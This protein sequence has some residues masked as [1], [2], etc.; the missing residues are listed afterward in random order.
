MLLPYIKPNFEFILLKLA[1]L[2]AVLTENLS[3]DH[4]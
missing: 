4:G 2:L 3:V 1:V